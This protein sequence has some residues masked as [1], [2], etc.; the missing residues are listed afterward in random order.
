LK[1][2]YKKGTRFDIILP[3]NNKYNGRSYS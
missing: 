3:L 1:S 2:E